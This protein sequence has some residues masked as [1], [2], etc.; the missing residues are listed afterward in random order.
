[1]PQYRLTGTLRGTSAKEAWIVDGRL[2]YQEPE[3]R[4]IDVE[5]YVYPGLLDTHTHPGLNRDGNLLD[6][7]EVRRRLTALRS[8]GVTAVQDCGGQQD[9]GDDRIVGL[10]R[11]LHCGRHIAMYKRY[12]RHLAVETT[13]AELPAEAVKQFEA[14]DGWIKIVG[15]W[16]DRAAGDN[17]PLWPREALIDAVAAVHERGGKVTVHTFTTEAIDDLLEAGVDGIEHGTGM[18]REHLDE[19]ARRGILL[20]PT[21]HQIR[22]FPE[23]AAAG[24]KFP[25][26]RERMLA[27]D[28][29]RREHLAMIV[30]SGVPLLM[31]SDTAEEVAEVSLPHELIDAVDDGMPADLVMAA[32]S[33]SGRSRL[34]FTSWEEGA[35]A[36]FVVY[37]TDPER[38]I[39]TV[40][41]PRDVFID[42]IRS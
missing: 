19:A 3:G 15:D 24:A 12:V 28:A 17:L 36:D 16:I 26:Y 14:S 31:G 10:P 41:A 7:S 5:G 9:P 30:E 34:G 22:K 25:A 23:F 32:A 13:P 39:F 11:I 33:Y 38:D 18:T 6:R 4:V 29:Q 8:W 21:V 1:M 42:G 20:T 37:S 2:T 27:M 35:P 40:L